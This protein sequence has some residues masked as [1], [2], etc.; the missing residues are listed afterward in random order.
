MS[1]PA[2]APSPSLIESI[3]TP[4]VNVTYS[5]G[6]IGYPNSAFVRLAVGTLLTAVALYIIKPEWAF[7]TIKG[8]DGK[9]DR[10]VPKQWSVTASDELKNKSPEA[11]TALPWW[12][13]AFAVG[14]A[15]SLFV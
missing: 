8:K 4:I 13:L 15:F 14:L 2:P 1:T 3:M 7:I 10:T 9:N 5:L 11:T 6:L 12:L